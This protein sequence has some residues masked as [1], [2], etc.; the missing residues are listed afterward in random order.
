MATVADLSKSLSGG[1]AETV[2]GNMFVGNGFIGDVFTGNV[3]TGNVFIGD[4]IGSG[5]TGTV[6]VGS[7]VAGTNS[8]CE[9][10]GDIGN[11]L[12]ADVRKGS[13]AYGVGE[14][15]GVMVVGSGVSGTATTC[16][17]EKASG[18][19]FPFHAGV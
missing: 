17:L 13:R 10:C 3:F 5:V 16:E 7:D 15:T 11:G 8:V 12:G 14:V 2:E 19:W 1:I 6:G 4:T 18:F 9:Y